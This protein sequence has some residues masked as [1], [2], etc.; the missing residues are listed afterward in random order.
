[1]IFVVENMLFVTVF[2][3]IAILFIAIM[4]ILDNSLNTSTISG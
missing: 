4:F 1:M 3:V 2:T